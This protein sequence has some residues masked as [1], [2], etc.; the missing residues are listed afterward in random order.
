M[1]NLQVCDFDYYN[2][3]V[4][5]ILNRVDDPVFYVFSNTH[6]DLEWIKKL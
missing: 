3:G 2:R 4:N 5:E 1:E 6:D